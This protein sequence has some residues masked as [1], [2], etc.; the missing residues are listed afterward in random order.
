MRRMPFTFLVL[1]RAAALADDFER[2]LSTADVRF[3]AC[4]AV[5]RHG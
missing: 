1:D 3:V 5:I 4:A 2:F